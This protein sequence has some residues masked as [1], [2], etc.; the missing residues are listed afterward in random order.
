[1]CYT[2]FV[3]F[4]SRRRHTR[5]ALVTGVSDVCSSDLDEH[6]MDEKMAEQSLLAIE[7]ADVVLFLVDA[8]AGFTAAD[9]MIAEHLRKR[10]KRSYVVANKVDNIDPDMARAEF[11]PL[12]MGQDRKSTRLNSS[13]ETAYRR[14]YYA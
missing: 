5:C 10:N 7:E 1:M 13:H 3:F 14:P 9:Q 4:S 8:K 2:L 11:A 12:G 6:G